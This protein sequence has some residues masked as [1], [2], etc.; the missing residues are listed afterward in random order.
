M[1]HKHPLRTFI[2]L[3]VFCLI[4]AVVQVMIL[5]KD[6]T[7]GELLTKMKAEIKLYENENIELAQKIASSSSITTIAER[8]RKQGMTE[9]SRLVSLSSPLPIALSN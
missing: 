5:N 9:G 7:S 4:L 2:I 3:T 1:I 6:S 8:A